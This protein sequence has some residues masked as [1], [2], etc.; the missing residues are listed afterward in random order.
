MKKPT[1]FS[2]KPVVN[3]VNGDIQ[4]EKKHLTSHLSWLDVSWPKN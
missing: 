1:V 3:N 2:A 4:A